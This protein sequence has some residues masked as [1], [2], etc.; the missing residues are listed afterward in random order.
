MGTFVLGL[1]CQKGGTTWLHDYLSHS[2]QFDPGFRKEYQVLNAHFGRGKNWRALKEADAALERIR[3]GTATREDADWLRHAGFHADVGTYYDYFTELLRPDGVRAT[4]DI[5][6]AYAALGREQL[7]EVRRVFAERNI[8]TVAVFLLRDPA[9][10]IWSSIRMGHGRYEGVRAKGTPEE[11][12][13]RNFAAQHQAVRTRYDRTLA[14]MDAVFG[15]DEIVVEFY[16]RLFDRDVL[17]RICARIGIDFHE[18]DF[19]HRVNVSKT[20]AELPVETAKK[21]AD[22]YG[23]VYDAVAERFPD[24]DLDALWPSAALRKGH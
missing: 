10:R 9:E 18:P 4:G 23:V 7:A 24:V 8:R 16:E 6:P 2:P 1:G 22:H 13:L 12:A 3:E 5:T 11:L 19:G 14:A 20:K 21:I 17:Q 15:P